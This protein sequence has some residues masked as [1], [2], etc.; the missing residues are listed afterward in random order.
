VTISIEFYAIL[1]SM[2]SK[3]SKHS[4]VFK[5]ISVL[6]VQ[7][8]FVSNFALA[9]QIPT[10][11]TLAPPL[12]TAPCEIVDNGDGTY[13]VRTYNESIQAWKEERYKIERKEATQE[14]RK[15]RMLGKSLHEAWAFVDV[16]M[17]IG[18]MLKIAEDKKLKHPKTILIPLI[19]EHIKN[20]DGW[21]QVR[22]EGYDVDNL[23]EIRNAEGEVV[24]FE[25]P[26]IRKGGIP[27]KMTYSLTEADDTITEIPIRDK[28][29][30]E[31]LYTVY[32]KAEPIEENE[33][34][35]LP[36]GKEDDKKRNADKHRTPHRHSLP[37]LEYRDYRLLTED[38]FNQF[39]DYANSG[40]QS[41]DLVYSSDE[42]NK[43][44]IISFWKRE[45]G[46]H[47]GNPEKYFSESEWNAKLEDFKLAHA[48]RTRE[49]A[50]GH[51]ERVDFGFLFFPR[52]EPFKW[53]PE[54]QAPIRLRYEE[55]YPFSGE[56]Y[57]AYVS[58]ILHEAEEKQILIEEFF[59]YLEN[60]KGGIPDYLKRFTMW[61]DHTHD[62]SYNTFGIVV[63]GIE[64]PPDRLQEV[65]ELI[66]DFEKYKPTPKPASG[67]TGRMSQHAKFETQFG[68][69]IINLPTNLN[70]AYRTTNDYKQAFEDTCKPVWEGKIKPI[71][72]ITVKADMIKPLFIG[73]GYRVLKDE[74]D[75]LSVANPDG[76]NEE[77]N[78]RYE[79]IKAALR[80]IDFRGT[81]NDLI[82][83]AIVNAADIDRTLFDEWIKPILIPHIPGETSASYNQIEPQMQRI[84][85]EIARQKRSG[86][87]TTYHDIPLY[88]VIESIIKI[89]GLALCEVH[90]CYGESGHEFDGNLVTEAVE[91]FFWIVEEVDAENPLLFQIRS[92][93]YYW[94]NRAIA[95]YYLFSDNID[96]AVRYY[97]MAL[98]HK[99]DTSSIAQELHIFCEQGCA[100]AQ[101]VLDRLGAKPTPES[102]RTQ[103]VELERA[104]EA[105]I[106]DRAMQERACKDT[107]KEAQTTMVALS[108]DWIEQTL[109]GHPQ[110]VDINKLIIHLRKRCEKSNIPLVDDEN[111]DLLAAINKRI[112]KDGIKNPRV[113]VLAGQDTLEKDEYKVLKA[114]KDY[115]LFGVNR[116]NM[117]VNNYIRLV[118][119]ITLA[120]NITLGK[121]P[122]STHIEI[123]GKGRFY[124]FTP[125]AEKMDWEKLRP[126][127]AA[128]VSA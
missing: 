26:I 106:Y 55:N 4:L 81:L 118:E 97:Q 38:N 58:K 20:R 57:R 56:P 101:I 25:L 63:V 114:N 83:N 77:S 52:N 87:Y 61:S 49:R 9:T 54:A 27:V 45:W 40:P 28:E 82:C 10:E 78:Q 72:G 51:V 89:A 21:P 128:Q 18:Q 84:I 113:I 85:K 96:K 14:N 36:V 64:F 17:L 67:E 62:S 108:R 76:E 8:F 68:P 111:E 60:I 1:S 86:E 44:N 29:D 30:K 98:E 59:S 115:F 71:W 31:T 124:I 33:V 90:T 120:L 121:Q 116:E 94:G 7:A 99:N 102:E 6:I 13:S 5:A 19:K 48:Q 50:S 105:V 70:N 92:E 47:H 41:F 43:R 110:H 66:L 15:G 104:I 73:T 16:G 123:E 109:K 39:G 119:M 117:V 69:I 103:V 11:S 65:T 107:D 95:R 100:N 32:V 91:M 93:R 24:A 122:T 22:L 12:R 112:E 42:D 34:I 46:F 80:K 88:R 35:R 125:P 79:E 126:I 53:A 74:A 127:Y 23:E 3:R 2:L 37:G 75:E